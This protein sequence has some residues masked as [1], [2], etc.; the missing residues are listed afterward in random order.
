MQT[1]YREIES[2]QDILNLLSERTLL[3]YNDLSSDYRTHAI[4]LLSQRLDWCTANQKDID[5]TLQCIIRVEV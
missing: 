1:M 5:D 4:D 3:M 2:V